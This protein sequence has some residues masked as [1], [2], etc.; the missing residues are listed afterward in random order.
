MCSDWAFH[1][2]YQS[3]VA[4]DQLEG[5]TL[6]VVAEV[7]LLP[8]AWNDDDIPMFNDDMDDFL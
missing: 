1:L 5:H 2:T 8:S 6:T 4:L 3:S 7:P